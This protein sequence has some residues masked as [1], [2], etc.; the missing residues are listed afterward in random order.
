L[1]YTA[2]TYGGNPSETGR[3]NGDWARD[4]DSQT[5]FLKL[6]GDGFVPI[7]EAARYHEIGGSGR[8]GMVYRGS[9]SSDPSSPIRGDVYYNTS[10]LKMRIHNGT[11]WIE[12]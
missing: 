5:L 7:F 3:E 11:S 1:T 2:S 12:V 9:F 10:T 6:D 8:W 4:S